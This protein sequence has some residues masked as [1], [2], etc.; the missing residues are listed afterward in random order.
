MRVVSPNGVMF[1]KKAVREGILPKM[2]SEILDTRVMV[3]SSMGLH[4][5]NRHLL[6]VME[7]R[8]MGLK[9]IANVTYGYTGANFSGRMPCVELAD[10]IVQTAR[11]TLER[12]IHL[13]E[14]TKEWGARVV[15][16]DTDSMFVSLPN[17]TREE[18]FRIGKEIADRITAL[19]PKPVKLR[20]EKVYQPCVLLTKKRYFGFKYESLKQQEPVF[21][22]KG[23][24]TVRRDTCPAVSKLMEA[25][26]KYVPF[27]FSS[28]LF[29]IIIIFPFMLSQY[30]RILFR[31]NDLSQVKGFLQK[32]W[33]K[34]LQGKTLLQD[35]VFAKEV[36][37]GSYS[38]KGT[39]PP[40]A[41]VG[42]RQMM[43]D[44][45]REPLY[46]E[47]VRYVV[48]YGEPGSRLSD[49]VI[50]PEEFMSNPSLRLHG[51]YYIT[52]Q[53]IPALSRF[54]NLVGADL[55]A[56]LADL[57]RISRIFRPLQPE[58][59]GAPQRRPQG[60]RSTIDHY[61]QTTHCFLCD[62][63]LAGQDVFCASC[64]A[65]GAASSL[66]LFHRLRRLE[67][68]ER[69]LHTFC[70]ACCGTSDA[71]ISCV[72]LDCPLYSRRVKVS[73]ELST[74]AKVVAAF[75]VAQS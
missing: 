54:L 26:I 34:I 2:L 18:S 10:S 35:F 60:S 28:S 14:T 52:K 32:E 56:W 16:G 13:I 37:L 62:A 45:R 17:A 50:S 46:R 49:Q 66:Q 20:F 75:E 57:P 71:P 7:S 27:F 19:N 4:R 39:L 11:Q 23:V 72:S 73:R 61:Y 41:L 3:K 25:T 36:R 33:S 31:T 65:A 69:D 43:K 22:A 38:K 44:P 74:Q 1:V 67:K 48:V 53:I 51:H 68:K 21:D 63:V 70:S 12:A 64:V 24:E 59:P 30:R 55:H 47:R 40:S 9:Y 58:E 5:D 42:T 6:K 15:Y 29:F 8:Q